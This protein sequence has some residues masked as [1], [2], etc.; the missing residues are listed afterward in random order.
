MVLFSKDYNRREKSSDLE[1]YT[2]AVF[3]RNKA[4]NA[5][6]QS[7]AAGKGYI[8]MLRNAEHSAENLQVLQILS[9]A[10]AK[11]F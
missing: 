11:K 4:E 5:D 1:C 7:Y 6:F 2:V 3:K 8:T 9:N 10:S